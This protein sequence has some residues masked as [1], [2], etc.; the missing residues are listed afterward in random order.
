MGDL[1]LDD[2]LRKL[3]ESGA[4]RSRWLPGMAVAVAGSPVRYRWLRAPQRYPG[5]GHFGVAVI[6]RDKHGDECNTGATLAPLPE[7]VHDTTDPLTVQGLLLLLRE[8]MGDESM[9]AHPYR[10][11]TEWKAWTVSGWKR[12]MEFRSA[13]DGSAKTER[14]AIEAALVA[15]AERL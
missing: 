12:S 8:A 7:L 5:G 3:E 11:D 13:F 2:A 4:I 14:A 9:Y 10:H 15:C 6:T 1:T